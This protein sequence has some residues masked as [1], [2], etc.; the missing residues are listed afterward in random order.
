MSYGKKKVFN[1]H[2]KIVDGAGVKRA[3]E[4]RKMDTLGAVKYR[5]IWAEMNTRFTNFMNQ[6]NARVFSEQKQM[7]ATHSNTLSWATLNLEMHATVQE[8][9]AYEISGTKLRVRQRKRSCQCRIL[10]CFGGH[11]RCHVV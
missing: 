8:T 6:W 3:L 2:Q 10:F 5:C 1:C 11:S 4:L 9:K 7:T